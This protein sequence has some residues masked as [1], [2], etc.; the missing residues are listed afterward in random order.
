MTDTLSSGLSIIGLPDSG[1]ERERLGLLLAEL[2]LWKTAGFIH[3]E[4]EDVIVRHVLDC[5]AGA[6]I[7][8]GF[9][10]GR[11][12]DLGSGAGFPGLVLAVFLEGAEFT[13]VERSAK[14]AAFLENAAAVMKLGNITVRAAGAEEIREVFDVVTWRAFRPLA[15][16]EDAAAKIVR[17]GGVIA[18]FKGR[19]SRIE[20]ELGESRRS[21]SRIEIVPVAVPFLGEERHILIL[22]P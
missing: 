19:R 4:G 15:S 11:I 12:A 9:S 3:A 22:Q 5:A 21:W 17:P 16:I 20:E 2:E 14:R 10:P 6:G 18:A 13:L 8:G 7:I 1:P